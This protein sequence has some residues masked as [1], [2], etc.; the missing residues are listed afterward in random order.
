MPLSIRTNNVRVFSEMREYD[1]GAA[2]TGQVGLTTY[3]KL[4]DGDEA[5]QTSYW[6]IG[7]R[8]DHL[9]DAVARLQGKEPTERRVSMAPAN[10]IRYVGTPK[11]ND[12][13]PVQ[14]VDTQAVPA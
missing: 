11:Q 9:D 5:Y 14:T 4:D 6:E 10:D 3:R 1:N 13:L 8:S 7:G 12:L 2:V